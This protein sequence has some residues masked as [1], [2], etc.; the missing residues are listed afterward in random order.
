M[1]E[2]L[3]NLLLL[4]L[5]IEVLELF[6][7]ILLMNL[8]SFEPFCEC[9]IVFNIFTLLKIVNTKIINSVKK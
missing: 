8:V 4:L 6:Y 1:S 3:E 2:T 7:Y 5:L 9:I